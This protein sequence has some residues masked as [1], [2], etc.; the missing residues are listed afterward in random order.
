MSQPT[1]DE[2]SVVGGFRLVKMLAANRGRWVFAGG[3]L[4]DGTRAV[5]KICNLD[6]PRDVAHLRDEFEI[7]RVLRGFGVAEVIGFGIDVGQNL[8]YLALR[9][10]GASLATLQGAYPHYII[11][12]DLALVVLYVAAQS[13]GKIHEQGYCHGDV[14]PGN[15]LLNGHG[16]AVFTDLEFSVPVFRDE[17]F[18]H[19]KRPFAG[20]APFVAPELWEIGAAAQSP[21]ADVWALGVILYLLLTGEYP[22]GRENST[23]IVSAVRQ[24][25]TLDPELFSPP[26]RALL[27]Q[28]LALDATQR[29]KHGTAAATTIGDT[30]FTL[31]QNLEFAHQQ[32]V[33]GEAVRH[34]PMYAML[35]APLTVFPMP[36]APQKDAGLTSG[37][38]D[39]EAREIP[40]T[41]LEPALPPSAPEVD[42]HET[43]RSTFVPTPI[44]DDFLDVSS[45]AQ[46]TPIPMDH[47]PPSTCPVEEPATADPVFLETLSEEPTRDYYLR[48]RA[49]ARWFLRM[50]PARNFPLS[51]VF[52]G[53][54][55]RIRHAAGM[56]VTLGTNE[57]VLDPSDPFVEVEPHFPGCMVTPPKCRLD[58]SAMT[59]VTKFWVTPLAEG[60]LP[61]ACV[62]IIYHG[63][64]V[65]SLPTPTNVVT[66]AWAFVCLACGVLS[67]VVKQLLDGLGWNWTLAQEIREGFPILALLADRVGAVGTSFLLAII[68]LLAAVVL[69]YLTRPIETGDNVP[70]LDN[71]HHATPKPT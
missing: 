22:F 37:N 70:L 1:F 10:Y 30:L 36:D 39:E 24:P 65:E 50:N 45:V 43:A 20:T 55:L 23:S 3:D 61:E 63:R 28:L 12:T 51:V 25:P 17:K 57:I 9:A 8:A 60:P 19:E 69:Y 67:P 52:S 31:N 34:V 15:I 56:G 26:L 32:L 71:T 27:L 11:P 4:I 58:L 29:P 18:S 6:I 5:L 21:S 35:M 13:L 42:T 68:F 38:Q 66:R 2:N 48:R 49:A 59:T 47:Q 14:K 64:V 40:T 62:K 41:N 44:S 46:Q 33:L 54:K 7:L 53:K 16:E